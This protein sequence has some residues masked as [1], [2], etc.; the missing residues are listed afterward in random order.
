MAEPYGDWTVQKLKVEIV[1]RG[2]ALSGRK[3][4]FVERYLVF[5]NY[6]LIKKVAHI[7]QLHSGLPQQNFKWPGRPL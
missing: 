6:T 3:K 2:A 5:C 1:R 7:G 4:D